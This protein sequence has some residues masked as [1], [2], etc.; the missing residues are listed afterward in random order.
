MHRKQTPTAA[1]ARAV[2]CR[3]PENV[4]KVMS[5]EGWVAL[6]RS[7]SDALRTEVATR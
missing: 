7:G 5:S 6:C 3:L 1:R 4:I 2:V